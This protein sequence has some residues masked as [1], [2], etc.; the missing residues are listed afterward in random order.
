MCQKGYGQL[1]TEKPLERD[2]YYKGRLHYTCTCGHVWTQA[3]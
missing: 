3:S 1:F 2:R